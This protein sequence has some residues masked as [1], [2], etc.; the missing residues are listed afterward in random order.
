MIERRGALQIA[1]AG[2][3]YF[4]L[5]LVGAPYAEQESEDSPA[6]E[7]F[8]RAARDGRPAQG[9]VGALV[10]FYLAFLN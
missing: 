6:P 7:R 10:L 5:Q 9:G 2:L 4:S 3:P 8:G 1:R